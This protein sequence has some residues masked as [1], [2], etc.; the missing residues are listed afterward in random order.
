[1]RAFAELY[2]RLDATTSSN[3]KLAAMHDYFASA[4]P[5][6]AAWAVYFLSGGRP[7]QLV[8]TRVLRE[9]AMTLASLPEWLFE[10]SYQAVGDLA[11]TLSLLLPQADHSND[12]GLAIWM[13]DKLL[14]LRGLPPEELAARLPMFWSQLDRISLMVCIKLI[15]GS[16]RVGVSKLLVTR[17]LAALA[18]IDS[19][20][21]AQR[22]VG[23]TD[24]SHRPSAERYLKLIAPESEDEHAQR[25]GQPYP[26]FLAHSLQ[27]PAD[28]FETL[29]GA[30]ENWQV[31]W[32][33]DGIRAQ[34]VKRDGRLWIWS[35]GEELVTDRFPELHTLVQCLPDGTVIDGEI[36]VWKAPDTNPESTPDSGTAF[37]LDSGALQAAPSVQPFA[38][39]QQRIG[40]KT[41]GK[42]ILADVPVV[43]LAYD[44]LEWQGDDWRSRPQHE[45]R[46]QLETLI[47]SCQS[48]VLMPSPVLTGKNWLDLATQRE[49]SRSLGVEGMMLK[50]RDSLYGVGRTK[51][52]G[53]WWKWKIDPF[54]V[55]A[56]LIYAQR[57]HGRRASLYSDYT[58]AVWDGPPDA[59]ERTLVP[60]AKAYSGLTDEEMRK[61]D[62]IVRKTTVEKFGPVSSV[63]PTLVFELGFEGIA[64]SKRHKSGIAVRF[65]RMLRWRQDK[66][67]AEAD[68]LATLQDLLN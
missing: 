29:L 26:F 18:N 61:V 38:L 62:A 63:T 14:P 21:V 42:K 30:A 8:P 44:L 48:E 36:V 59:S 22:L 60:F 46:T 58:F 17:A 50:A 20:R 27:Q 51:D 57:G 2:S 25:G 34:L 9:Q 40:R 4:A 7:R 33:W 52:M 68:S 32:K 67:V 24:L 28:Q 53:V 65:P 37:A 41:L 5:E 10:E 55:D 64:L 11:E 39:L 19:K 43:V 45:R 12:E 1:M 31:E 6:D 16:F 49:A 47:E 3:A 15:T 56:V 35:R 66:P 54:S 13:E 23:Y